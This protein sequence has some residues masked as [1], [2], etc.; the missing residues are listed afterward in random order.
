LL[1]D[2]SAYIAVWQ[3]HRSGGRKRAFDDGWEICI[4]LK[5]YKADNQGRPFEKPF[6]YMLAILNIGA[7]LLSARGL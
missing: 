4:G 5:F 1:F 7:P 3:E 2:Q 6:G